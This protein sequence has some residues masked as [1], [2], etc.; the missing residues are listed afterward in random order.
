MNEKNNDSN[1]YLK[2]DLEREDGLT[3]F[4]TKEDILSD[5]DIHRILEAINRRKKE[6]EKLE[7][8]LKRLLES[9]I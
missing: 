2:I 7:N 6:I 5:F 8:E 4:I 1:K 9:D 3:L